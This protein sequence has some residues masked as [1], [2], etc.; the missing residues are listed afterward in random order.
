MNKQ[1]EIK[2]ESYFKLR[3]VSPGELD[4]KS[5][6]PIYL[7]NTLPKDTESKI[8]DIGCGFGSLMQQFKNIGYKNTSGIDLNTES[9]N[10]CKEKGFDVELINNIGE[11]SETNSDKF[12][13]ATMTHVIEHIKK[14]EIIDTLINI[15]KMLRPGGTLYIATP[16][17]QAK[18][19]AYWMFEDFTHEVIFTAGS[20][21]YVLK[22]AGFSEVEFID[23]DGVENSRVKIFKKIL[24]KIYRLCTNFWD[25]VTGVAYHPENPRIDT[26][27]IKVAARNK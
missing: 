9:I 23:K 17:G 1:Q 12:D 10:Y 24:L 20:L 3:N 4:E 7:K 14:E 25:K 27:E 22:A 26:W 16:N 6:P 21:S 15:R 5:A 11:Y 19:G 18:S 8:L 13:F 2:K